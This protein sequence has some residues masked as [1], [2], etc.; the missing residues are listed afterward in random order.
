MIYIIQTIL[1]SIY[2][3]LST[4]CKEYFQ[5]GRKRMSDRQAVKQARQKG[6]V[7]ILQKFKKFENLF[8]QQAVQIVD[9]MRLY[10]HLTMFSVRVSA[11]R[12][13]R[14]ISHRDAALRLV[15]LGQFYMVIIDQISQN[16]L[17]TCSNGLE[18]IY[19]V[20]YCEFFKMAFAKILDF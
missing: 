17:P 16:Q 15:F 12:K 13:F 5:N 8:Q 18:K 11:K 10:K 20:E 14:Y 3:N 9:H 1:Y 4:I 7:P 19:M 2:H 6:N